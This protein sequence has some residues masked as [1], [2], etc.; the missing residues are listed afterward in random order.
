MCRVASVWARKRMRDCFCLSG[1]Y[2]AL[3]PWMRTRIQLKAHGFSI[4]PL[5]EHIW[6]QQPLH[7]MYGCAGAHNSSQANFPGQS[8]SQQWRQPCYWFQWWWP[9]IIL[10]MTS[11]P[12]LASVAV[13][14]SAVA[15]ITA[16]TINETSET[17]PP[18]P[19]TPP[20]P[21]RLLHA[22]AMPSLLT[23]TQPITAPSTISSMTPSLSQ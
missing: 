16:N 11:T 22:M 8:L 10:T 17:S 7:V 18:S 1:L 23:S 4:L 6:Y 15:L 13:F 14:F 20:P 9:I 21:P 3:S 5:L 12:I 2:T 19:I